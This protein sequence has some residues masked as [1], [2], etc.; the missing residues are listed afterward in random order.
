MVASADRM[1]AL[2]ERTRRGLRRLT[3]DVSEA[4][5]ARLRSAAKRASRLPIAIIGL[6]FSQLQFGHRLLR[7]LP[8]APGLR[9]RNSMSVTPIKKQR[10]ANG[11]K[12]RICPMPRSS[13]DSARNPTASVLGK[14]T[15]RPSRTRV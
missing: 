9:E 6:L 7:F 4:I 5:S 3:M 8:R 10:H 11:P 2:R 1:R 12:G 15:K 13:P 14:Q